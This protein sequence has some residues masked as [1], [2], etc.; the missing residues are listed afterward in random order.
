MEFK[1]EEIAKMLSDGVAKAMG[2]T[3]EKKPETDNVAV[4]SLES[5]IDVLSDFISKH[6]KIEKPKTIE[7][8][9]EE[10]KKSIL[11]T[12]KEGK[13]DKTDKK[14]E[15][16]DKPLENITAKSLKAM[17]ADAVK[18][19]GD[20]VVKKSKPKGQ[21]AEEDAI[22]DLIGMMAKSGNVDMGEDA[23]EDDSEE[24]ADDGE[25][26]EKKVKKSADSDIEVTT[27]EAYDD[28]GNEIPMA[29][30]QRIQKLDNYL[31][32]KLQHEFAK[33]GIVTEK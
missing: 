18:E 12:I 5:K 11:D 31:G 13:T 3:E 7:E 6:V 26:P 19:T 33:R 29:K 14:E 32:D 28:N 9:M 1:A 21:S 23:E 2:A 17:I 30:R 20:K 16:E 22:D 24:D 15:D 8:Q 25:K 27:V 4:K 10:M